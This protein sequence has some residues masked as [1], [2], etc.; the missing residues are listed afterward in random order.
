MFLL[1]L[2]NLLS[3]AISVA[4]RFDTNY[5]GQQ[6]Q[7]DSRWKLKLLLRAEVV[8]WT[9]WNRMRSFTGN[10]RLLRYGYTANVGGPRHLQTILRRVALP[11][12]DLGAAARGC[13]KYPTRLNV[14]PIVGGQWTA[15]LR[16]LSSWIITNIYFLS[17]SESFFLFSV[18]K[19]RSGN[20]NIWSQHSFYSVIYYVHN[21]DGE[22]NVVSDCEFERGHQGNRGLVG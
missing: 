5:L 14:Y 4:T 12:W 8:R 1:T 11:E 21:M 17:G 6:T 18:L 2:D 20:W 3:S 10:S 19:A 7:C 13:G 15:P 9:I 16:P 22:C